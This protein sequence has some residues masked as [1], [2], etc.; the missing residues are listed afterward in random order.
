MLVTLP[1]LNPGS[2]W[3]S[4]LNLKHLEINLDICKIFMCHAI[5]SRKVLRIWKR[6]EIL[7]EVSKNESTAANVYN[8]WYH[9]VDTTFGYVW[10]LQSHNS[11]ETGGYSPGN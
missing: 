10:S 3:L 7:T 8:V 11:V 9:V 6:T 5:S 2:C 4:S 1:S